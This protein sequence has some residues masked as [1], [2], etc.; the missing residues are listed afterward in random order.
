MRKIFK[1]LMYKRGHD[2][3]YQ[4]DWVLRKAGQVI[5]EYEY[6]GA[7]NA[8]MG[9][10]A[11]FQGKNDAKQGHEKDK[12][13]EERKESRALNGANIMNGFGNKGP[14]GQL[15][16]GARKQSATKRKPT[17]VQQASVAPRQVGG[18]TV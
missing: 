10:I 8:K 7:N 13:V 18:R 6:A 11:A 3:D 14:S 17:T 2:Y 1:D 5:P 4:Y 16:A 9:N 12:F 15:H